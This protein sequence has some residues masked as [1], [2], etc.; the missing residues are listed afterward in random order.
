MGDMK[1]LKKLTSCILI[2]A[3]AIGMNIDTAMAAVSGTAGFSPNWFQA[4][5]QGTLTLTVN[6]T[7]T[8]NIICV[9]VK[10]PSTSYTWVSGVASGWTYKVS[11]D[12]IIF[13]G[14][15]ISQGGSQTF[16]ITFS[17][18][19]ATQGSANI[20][21]KGGSSASN[22][23]S[24]PGGKTLDASSTGALSIGTDGTAPVNNGIL[25]V[26]AISSTEI[27]V[28]ANAG[29]DA[30]SGLNSSPYQF[31]ETTTNSGGTDS[32]WQSSTTYSDTGLSPNTQYCYRVKVRDF[33]LNES[34]YS[35]QVC[36][37]TPAVVTDSDG[38]GL[39]DAQEATLGTNPNNADSDGDGLNDGAEVNTHN[40]NPL[41]SDSDSDGLSDNAEVSTHLTNP[42]S[43]DSDS[44]GL[45][46][47]AEV[48]THQTN[49]LASDSDSD[50]LSDSVEI[51]TEN[52]DPLD[53]DSDNDGL[54]DGA[55]VN[56]YLT[57]P[58]IADTDGDGISD[59]TEI[60][61]GTDPLDANDPAIPPTDTDGDGL[62][63]SA[64]TNTYGTNPNMADTDGDGLNDGAEVNTYL[65][66]PLVADTDGDGISDGTEITNGTDPL[67][68]NDPAIPPTD[69]DGDGLSDSAETSIYGTNPNM[70]DTDGD[71]LN[72]G[73][74]VSTYLTD[75][76]LA[77][78]DGDGI[79][80]GTEITNGTDP[81][82]AN[83][84][85][86]PDLIVMN[87]ARNAGDQL[88]FT[89]KNQ[90][91]QNASGEGSVFVWMDD[92]YYKSYDFSSIDT[93]FMTA[94]SQSDF[95]TFSQF[96]NPVEVKA[97]VDATNQIAERNES[98]N[99]LTV[100]FNAS[101]N[102]DSDNDGLTDTDE[103][104]IHGTNPNIADTD[105][106][107]LNDGDEVNTYNTNPSD[108]DSDDDGINDGTEI[109]ITLTNPLSDDSD[110]DGLS[111]YV[112]VN[113]YNTDPNNS[114]TDNDAY[115]DGVELTNGTDP[116][117]P[118]DP[119]SSDYEGGGG[120]DNT[121]QPAS[122]TDE[123]SYGGGAITYPETSS[124]NIA[125]DIITII[126]EE[127]LID[128]DPEDYLI[129]IE[130]EEIVTIDTE[131]EVGA[132][133]TTVPVNSPGETATLVP[134]AATI[135]DETPPEV[136]IQLLSSGVIEGDQLYF[137]GAIS[138]IGGVVEVIRISLDGGVS[139]FPASSVTGLGT[140][141]VNFSFDT[142]SLVDGNY[143]VMV[144]AEDNSG[145]LGE[146]A[147]Y[148]IIIDKYD[149]YIGTNLFSVGVLGV[150]PND[151]LIHSSA[152]GITEDFYIAVGGGAT[153]VT[154]TDSM[155]SY[156][157]AYI[158]EIN[159]W[160][161]T[162]TYT[163]PGYKNFTVHA[164][165]GAGNEKEKQ[166]DSVYVYDAGAVTDEGTEEKISYYSVE[167]YSKTSEGD[168][169]IWDS[170]PFNQK[171]PMESTG[172]AFILPQGTYYIVVDA[173]GYRESTSEPF[174]IEETGV[175][176]PEL[177]LE[178]IP[179]FFRNGIA[180]Y[181]YSQI[182]WGTKWEVASVEVHDNTEPEGFLD[183]G[184]KFPEQELFGETIAT[185]EYRLISM[186]PT[187]NPFGKMQLNIFE[188]LQD[189]GLK[190]NIIVFS[191]I[192]PSGL[193]SSFL[194]RGLETI[195]IKHDKIGVSSDYINVASAPYHYLIAPDGT[196]FARSTGVLS[197]EKINE[198]FNQIN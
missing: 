187:W 164:K 74:E 124:E 62:S 188:S 9:A 32:A 68:A 49:P 80:D 130:Q 177:S 72:D 189:E 95:N 85:A 138:D 79:N 163:D 192:E 18:P 179:T 197:E 184:D 26:T 63:D 169:V 142:S 8:T 3:M 30:N 127:E 19:S 33:V 88:V 13:D 117:D 168:W 140:R 125:T 55:E 34:T 76:L 110:N 161:T 48:N 134:I 17:P 115:S 180:G 28:I 43:S 27:Q 20:S 69:T 191:T 113:T 70:A 172:G 131:A 143:R 14:G 90:G 196:I 144:Y 71:G 176:I 66:D 149:P 156:N 182:D 175:I 126:S 121:Q 39:T 61:N 120:G 41:A 7:G 146:S 99:C 154:M 122:Q 81:L 57:D 137:E 21:V 92:V 60:T 86:S 78:T 198:L 93:T 102:L 29:S 129:P 116:L 42:N 108:G 170:T 58:L 150:L 38:D 36:A 31:D 183:V 185:D 50:G 190:D 103:I 128:L 67:D 52:T 46:D 100:N 107:I 193:L 109:F 96:E 155:Q 54:N 132:S 171:N 12:S 15:P 151:S 153:E 77:D 24:C 89:L 162:V 65:T 148:E 174:K 83:D 133:G 11:G 73:A 186:F 75:P 56:T 44:D 167:I 10:N 98:N 112:E 152:V 114:D 158:P 82:D 22:S 5:T 178:K 94:G 37:T 1:K 35:A 47:G 123:T 119:S 194:A 16:S 4:G 166:L 118:L 181:L 105:G 159:L 160:K 64:E 111:D 139:T 104:N 25:S 145:N 195:E 6:G 59:G 106:D 173:N 147:S 165:D 97:C 101:A 40:T 2:F 23:N 51:N 157:L 45:S 84:P 91:N 136:E 141:N 53:S 135:G 87:I